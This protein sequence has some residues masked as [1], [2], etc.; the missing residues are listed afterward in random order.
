MRLGVL[1]SGGK[2][3]T[4]ALHRASEYHEIVCLITLSPKREDS[5]MFHYPNTEFVELQAEAMQ[6]PL[7][8]KETSGEKEKELKE[9]EEAIAEAKDIYEIEGVVTGAVRSVYQVTRIQK[10]CKKLD[11]WCFNPLWLNDEEMLLKEVFERG[12]NVIITMVAA[13]PLTKDFLGKNLRKVYKDLISLKKKFGL[14][15]VG[16]GGEF[17]TFVLDAPLFKKRVEIREFETFYKDYRGIF[18]IKHAEL[19]E[20]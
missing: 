6:L 11:L 8:F 18:L 15:L 12:F 2:D 5:Y 19:L 1:Y 16:E 13:Y 14:S 3:S 17:E 7:I 4:L 20:K 9:L 10:I